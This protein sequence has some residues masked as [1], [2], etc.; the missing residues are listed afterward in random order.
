MWKPFFKAPKLPTPSLAGLCVGLC[1]LTAQAGEELR[2]GAGSNA[3]L[4][5]ESEITLG[6][7]PGERVDLDAALFVDGQEDDDLGNGLSW[8][9]ECT[10][11]DSCS[12]NFAGRGPRAGCV[13]EVPREFQKIKITVS[14]DSSGLS[15]AF[16]L[17]NAEVA[18]P[19]PA[20]QQP[21]SA[22]PHGSRPQRGANPEAT[23]YPAEERPDA[24]V[25]HKNGHRGG[26][27]HPKQQDDDGSNSAAAAS[28]ASAGTAAANASPATSFGE[29]SSS[30]SPSGGRKRGH[31]AIDDGALNVP[32]NP[33]YGEMP[34]PEGSSARADKSTFRR[35][36]N[37][38]DVVSVVS[39]AQKQLSSNG[40]FE[41][42]CDGDAKQNPKLSKAKKP[43]KLP[44]RN[45]LGKKAPTMVASAKK[46]V[47]KAPAAK[48]AAS[49]AP[50]TLLAVNTK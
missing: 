35:G 16:E 49:P 22:H 12:E 28:P 33:Y 3:L 29:V 39:C 13:Y 2:I 27:R 30:A 5:N 7:K 21:G 42:V 41:I 9:A 14:D 10:G 43:K 23:G 8:T 45:M 47:R 48:A 38:D 20:Q 46:P 44:A 34:Y 17:T 1:A 6:V 25:G 15:A 24:S 50:G 11:S 40:K 36:Q 4:R 19:A 37:R 32:M 18:S 26:G 31:Q